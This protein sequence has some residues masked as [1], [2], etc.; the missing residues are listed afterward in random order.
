[1]NELDTEI[2]RVFGHTNYYLS[3]SSNGADTVCACIVAGV[4]DTVTPSFA[5]E[6]SA[7]DALLDHYRSAPSLNEA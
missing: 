7:L 5:D 2:L 6:Q 4:Q 1:M 3:I